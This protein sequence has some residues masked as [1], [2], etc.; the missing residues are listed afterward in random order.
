MPDTVDDAEQAIPRDPKLASQGLMG[1]AEVNAVPRDGFTTQESVLSAPAPDGAQQQIRELDSQKSYTDLVN[2]D[3]TAPKK[4]G[5]AASPTGQA[6]S[7]PENHGN[8]P[9]PGPVTSTVIS[10]VRGRSLISA[11]KDVLVNV[12]GNQETQVSVPVTS[13]TDQSTHRISNENLAGA[14]PPKQDETAYGAGAAPYTPQV[15][16]LDGALG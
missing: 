6:Q 3:L 11:G 5:R 10:N 16:T 8:A 13:G 15:P 12:N 7:Q 9:T 14:G 1:T 4:S 2:H